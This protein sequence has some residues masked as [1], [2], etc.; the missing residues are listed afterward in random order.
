[1][2]DTLGIVKECLLYSGQIFTLFSCT[3]LVFGLLRPFHS[4]LLNVI[5]NF[6]FLIWVVLYGIWF[7]LKHMSYDL[8]ILSDFLF[9]GKDCKSNIEE[10]ENHWISK[11]CKNHEICCLPEIYSIIKSAS[12]NRSYNLTE[13]KCCSIKSRGVIIH[14]LIKIF[15]LSFNHVF[16]YVYCINSVR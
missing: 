3:F 2:K 10:K 15:I 8:L 13:W 6:I 16:F 14:N 7:V 12:N 11:T 1:M 9:F 5:F 4:L